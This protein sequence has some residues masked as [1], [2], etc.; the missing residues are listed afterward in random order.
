MGSNRIMGTAIVGLVGAIVGSFSMML[1]ASTHFANVAGPNNT[2]PALS[3]APLRS[4]MSD[5]DRII[6]AVKRVTPS[7]VQISVTANGQ[8]LV[9]AD[10]FQQFFG[11]Q[12]QPQM[13]H[14]QERGSGS[15]FV[16]SKSG[17]IV[18]NAHVV[19]FGNGVTK[20]EVVFSNGD[21][22]PAHLYAANNGNDIALI[23]VDHYAKLPPPVELGDSDKL[24][25]GQWAIAIG[26]PF[27]LKQTVTLGVVSGFNRNET[28]GGSGRSV[29][30]KGLLQTSAP[31]NPG[32]SGGPLIDLE[33]RLIGVN[34]ATANPQMG[35]QGIGFAIP[36]NT[37]KTTALALEQHP[38][39]QSGTN[40]G[41][42]GV[43][44]ATVTDSIRTQLNYQGKGVA[45]GGVVT[46]SPADQAGMQPGD[47][48]QKINGKDVA[49]VQ[50]FQTTIRATKIGKSV[51]MQVWRGGVKQL[52]TVKV[53]EQP[54][55]VQGYQPQPLQG[56]P[57][58]TQP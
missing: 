25:A 15:G 11:G 5:Q 18:T 31:I 46:G 55:N 36:V 19:N 14:F 40:I 17:L 8:L 57:G 58:I 37:M 29:D 49:T 24:Q 50:E 28:I 9:P 27:E 44:I 38:G 3:A 52:V 33:G 42:I 2:P 26:E 47:V 48:V 56:N 43:Q 10:P 13:R 23:K 45:V 12:Q 20:I 54:Q 34:S 22:V 30:Y 41:Y 35:A 51:N 6:S 4:G 39:I 32:N 16:F 53:G 1:Y 7:V 21:R